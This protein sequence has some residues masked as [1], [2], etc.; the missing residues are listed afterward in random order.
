VTYEVNDGIKENLRFKIIVNWL[1]WQAVK[2]DIFERV[3]EY[4]F[5]EF[6]A[7]I[8]IHE[9][10]WRVAAA[11]HQAGWDV[12]ITQSEED[13]WIAAASKNTGYGG[14]AHIETLPFNDVPFLLCRLAEMAWD[15]DK[16]NEG[17]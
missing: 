14:L 5:T 11:M 10:P 6:S 15:V 16:E 17:R 2:F 8:S 3:H 7:V 1:G 12:R 9:L 13:R 4:P